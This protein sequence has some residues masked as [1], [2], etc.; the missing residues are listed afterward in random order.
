MRQVAARLHATR[1]LASENYPPTP[2]RPAWLTLQKIITRFPETESALQAEQRIAH[3]TE[4]ERMILARHDAR[5]V[6]MPEGVKNIGLLD[7]T[8]FLKPQEVEPGKLAG[9]ARKTSRGAPARFRSA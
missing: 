4:A 6:D 5:N 1:R 2:N 7:S 9:R 3:L 8:E